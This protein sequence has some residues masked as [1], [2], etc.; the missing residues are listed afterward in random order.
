ML[1]LVGG[2]CIIWHFRYSKRNSARGDGSSIEDD[3]KADMKYR[4]QAF[5]GGDMIETAP[6]APDDKPNGTTTTTTDGTENGGYESFRMI[7][8]L[9]LQPTHFDEFNDDIPKQCLQIYSKITK[10]Q[11]SNIRI[12][13]ELNRRRRVVEDVIAF[14]EYGR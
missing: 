7:V 9:I 5:D 1:V 2:A 4:N 6:A 13:G 3:P 8:N 11:C 12:G 10:S 14:A